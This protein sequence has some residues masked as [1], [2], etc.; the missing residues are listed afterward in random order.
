MGNGH[1]VANLSDE[2]ETKPLLVVKRGEESGSITAIINRQLQGD[3][4]ET[5]LLDDEEDDEGDGGE[6][7]TLLRGDSDALRR[8]IRRLQYEPHELGSPLLNAFKLFAPQLDNSDNNKQQPQ[9]QQSS[10]QLQS[11]PQ[12]QQHL[13]EL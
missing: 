13:V 2:S 8:Q 3:E 4:D 11:S 5:R 12:Q 7:M 9:Q 10:P 6:L 1:C